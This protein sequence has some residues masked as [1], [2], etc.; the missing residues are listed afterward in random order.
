MKRDPIY[1]LL[2]IIR[3][4]NNPGLEYEIQHWIATFVK[5]ASFR[6]YSDFLLDK[7]NKH[8]QEYIEEKLQH[9]L[10]LHLVKNAAITSKDKTEL[11]GTV[12][13][14]T[15]FVLGDGTPSR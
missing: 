9:D 12:I 15:I 13:T 5:T 2:N 1:E 7:R 8:A 6:Y 10:A 14:K 3:L 4:Q 11:G